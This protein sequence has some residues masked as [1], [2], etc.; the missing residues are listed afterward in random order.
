MRVDVIRGSV[1]VGGIEADSVGTVG[2]GGLVG[3]GGFSG[4]IPGGDFGG[5]GIESKR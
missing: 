1:G 5:K 3:F 2:V 4:K